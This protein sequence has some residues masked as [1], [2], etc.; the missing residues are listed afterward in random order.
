VRD[1]PVAFQF[2]RAERQQ[3]RTVQPNYL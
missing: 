2:A 3:L 1:A